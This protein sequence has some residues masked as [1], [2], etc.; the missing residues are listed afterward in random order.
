[1]INRCRSN[2][3]RVY[4][5]IVINHTTGDG[6]DMNPIH[7]SDA[8]ETWGPKFGSGNSPF[9]TK[10]GQIKNNYYTNQPPANEYPAIPYFPSDFHCGKG[11]ADWDDPEELCYGAL[12]GLEDINTEKEY[13]KRRIA[14]KVLKIMK[15]YK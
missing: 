8:C 12:A 15:F 7:Y 2:N 1:M 10:Y 3:V 5:E 9:Y 6:N 11:I 4:A 14:T 13:P